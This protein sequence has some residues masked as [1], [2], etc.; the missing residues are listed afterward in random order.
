[1]GVGWVQTSDGEKVLELQRRRGWD[2]AAFDS[3]AKR[4]PTTGKLKDLNNVNNQSRFLRKGFPEEQN[5]TSSRP[6]IHDLTEIEHGI[7]KPADI[8]SSK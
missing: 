5:F 4:G 3:T 8:Q 7:N 1:M 2:F 6:E